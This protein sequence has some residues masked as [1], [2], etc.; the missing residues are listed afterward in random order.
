M[1]A[2]R[3]HRLRYLYGAAV[4]ALSVALASA[5]LLPVVATQVTIETTSNTL[6]T[7]FFG[8][9]PNVVYISDQVGYSFFTN[10]ASDM[11][12]RKTT[13][14]GT[15]WGSQVTLSSSAQYMKWAIWYD[16]WTPGDTTGTLV[17]LVMIVAATDD[18]YYMTLNTSGDSTSGVTNISSSP[19][20]AFTNTFDRSNVVS[21]TRAT[22]G[23]LLAGVH[24]AGTSSTS[25]IVSCA[26]TCTTASNWSD[27]SSSLDTAAADQLILTPLLSGQV[28][29]IRFDSS[30]SD[31]QS[32]IYNGSAW[33]GSWTNIDL[34]AFGNTTETA[35]MSAV[36]DIKTGHVHL[37][38]VADNSTLGTNDDI[39]TVTYNGSSWTAKTDVLT[40][41]SKGLTDVSIAL[42]ENNGDIYVGYLAQTTPGTNTTTNVYWKKS[43][44][45]MSTWGS[46]QGAVNTSASYLVGLS[47]NVS[48]NQR[49]YA[50]WQDNTIADIMGDTLADLVPPTYDLS[51]YR[52]FANA[53]STD[54]GGALAAGD[55]AASL[56]AGGDAFRLRTLLHVGGD[57]ARASLDTLKLQYVDKGSGTCA[58]PSAGT[59]SSYTDVTAATLIAYND[60]ATPADG[61]ALTGNANDPVHSGH[62]TINQTYEELNNFTNSTAILNGQDGMWDFA[63]KDNGAAPGATYCLR[64]TKSD[65]T[66]LSNYTY[67]PAITTYA[68]AGP[69]LT[70]QLRG[71]QS[72]VN[73]VKTPFS[74]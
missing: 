26:S 59:P 36:T 57:G 55:T 12:Y 73:G 24:D 65:G 52:L 22:D 74:W 50:T 63:L 5:N 47:L 54:V 8:T 56:S 33:S 51:G 43:S 2:A 27:T 60:N 10:S 48:S 71:G 69:T 19:G 25:W 35:H 62:T 49:V 13:N 31:I 38:Y 44:N 34:N 14:G 6:N 3:H 66:A 21:I 37:A 67:Y 4:I 46:E 18:M 40:N 61:A 17:H 28:M 29:V 41:D 45:T 70:E 53:N 30:A 58:S 23:K 9:S 32:M 11:V 64:V 42:N 15:S 7:S 68:A 20:P 39:R 16:R 72:V 1:I